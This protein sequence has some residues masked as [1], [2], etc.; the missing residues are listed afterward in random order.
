MRPMDEAT[1]VENYI[2]AFIDA[3]DSEGRRGSL[4]GRTLLQKLMFHLRK[5][6]ESV[7][8][9]E[10]P[11][12]YGPFDEF[13]HVVLEQ[14]ETSG[15]IRSEPPTISLTDKGEREARSVWNAFGPA[16]RKAIQQLKAFLGDLTSD[17]I[18]AITYAQYPEVASD[19]LVRD[20][21]ARRGR[22][23]A[24]RL[25]RRGKVSPELGAR[26]AG[27]S[28]REFLK[29]LSRQ[30]IPVVEAGPASPRA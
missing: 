5:S 23:I 4:R 15:Y 25:V 24:V 9:K 22:S 29:H 28:L 16:E 11:H 3:P 7:P 14:L 30:G 12:F 2:L 10:F 26:I 20:D 13:A 1:A 17:E 18:L 21:L 19:S 27:M 8:G 6:L